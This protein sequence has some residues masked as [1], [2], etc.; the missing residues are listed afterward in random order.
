VAT[1]VRNATVPNQLENCSGRREF[2]GRV[3]AT[4]AKERQDV[5]LA[6]VFGAV[7]GSQ[8]SRSNQQS[9]KDFSALCASE[10]AKAVFD[11]SLVRE[12]TELIRIGQQKFAK[13]SLDL[14]SESVGPD[15]R[16]AFRQE[17]TVDRLAKSK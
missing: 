15:I 5:L 10:I 8:K 6:S 7:V 12:K 13:A 2:I 14:L 9:S 17:V 3:L 4:A 16:S 1:S 11:K